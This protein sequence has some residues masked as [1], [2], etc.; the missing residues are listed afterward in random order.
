MWRNIPQPRTLQRSY[1]H[2]SSTPAAATR[3]RTAQKTTDAPSAKR[4]KRSDQAS[5]STASEPTSTASAENAAA[6]WQPDP[7]LI[8]ANLV[9]SSE[10]NIAQMY[11][12][13]WPQIRTRFS[14][15]NRLQ[16]WYNFRL[17]T[18]NP[19]NLREQL[20]R[21]F[22][23]QPTV[24]KVN[25]AFGFILRNTET[26]ALQYHHPS[27]NNNLVLEQP[28]LDSNQA[29]LDRLYEQVNNIDFLEWVRQQRPNSKWMVD[30]ITNV[31][32]F[33]WRI[34]DHPIGRGKYLPGYI[35]DTYGFEAVENNANTGKP[36]EDNLC[37]FRCLALHNGC[38]TKNLERDTQYYYQQYRDAGLGKKKFHGVK[39]SELDNLEKLYEVNIQVYSLAP[40]QSHSEDEDNEENTPEIAATLLRRSHRH[41]SSTLYL[42]L[43]ENH[44]SYIKDLARYSKSFCCSRC[45][46]YWKRASDLRQH[47]RV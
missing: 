46:K 42:N 28:F 23:D 38:H 24:F 12:Q 26:G 45:G 31:T 29:D 47:E 16:D 39:K 40:T 36:Y 21:I 13:H 9:P 10:E 17:S 44:F 22:A 11:R 7:I 3:K 6:S 5:T 27:A 2:R 14:R 41:Y 4:P 34:R 35:A 30:L 8:P 33:V 18:I 32:W 37:F 19:A 1:S 25:F 43:Y 20:N 15:Y